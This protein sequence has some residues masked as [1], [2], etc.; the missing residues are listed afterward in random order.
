MSDSPAPF[1]RRY[2]KGY[3]IFATR[4]NNSQ[5]ITNQFMANWMSD[6]WMREFNRNSNT[7]TFGRYTLSIIL[8]KGGNPDDIDVSP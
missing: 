2:K 1:W 3:K 5:I 4:K 8:S 7:Q 6:A